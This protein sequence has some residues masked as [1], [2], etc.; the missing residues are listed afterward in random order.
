MVYSDGKK[1]DIFEKGRAFGFWEA[2]HLQHLYPHG[3]Y[4]VSHKCQ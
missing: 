1:G 2:A 4:I 3:S